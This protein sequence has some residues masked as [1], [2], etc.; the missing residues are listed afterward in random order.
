[1]IIDREPPRPSRV[2]DRILGSR[3]DLMMGKTKIMPDEGSAE[4]QAY[5][6]TPG[7][8]QMGFTL[9]VYHRSPKGV[10]VESHGIFFHDLKKPKWKTH[11]E[12]EFISFSHAGEAYT[13]S[14]RGLYD[15]YLAMMNSTLQTALEHE[16]SIFGEPVPG[17]EIIERVTVTDVAEMVRRSRENRDLRRGH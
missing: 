6:V 4:Y 11:E 12:T 17:A 8:P 5:V 9:G 1:M 16:P 10:S 7:F 14:G 15:M 2:V 13:L 3:S